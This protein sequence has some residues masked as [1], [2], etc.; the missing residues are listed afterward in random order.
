MINAA[1]KFNSLSI[2]RFVAQV[3]QCQNGPTD[4]DQR[5]DSET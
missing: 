2:L 4:C 1:W 3:D 5:A